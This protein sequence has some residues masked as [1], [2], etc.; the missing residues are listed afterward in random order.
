MRE[1]ERCKAGIVCGGSKYRK[2]LE[3]SSHYC[4]KILNTL[5]DKRK[6]IYFDDDEV[7]RRQIKVERICSTRAFNDSHI[8][9]LV[10]V[11]KCEIV[12]TEDKRS[13]PYLKR[14]DLYP[15][16]RR[17]KFYTNVNHEHLLT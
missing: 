1:I 15:N 10:G 4:H 3:R 5:R 14:R 8:A 17:P 16:G 13:L 12:C 7:N 2:E 9:A 11:S 6:I